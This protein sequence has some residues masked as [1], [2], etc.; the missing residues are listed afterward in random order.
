MS[1]QPCQDNKLRSDRCNHNGVRT[2]DFFGSRDFEFG[3]TN[4]DLLRRVQANLHILKCPQLDSTLSRIR[5]L[6][7]YKSIY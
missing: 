6:K 3:A 4:C 2:S 1:K 7:K 5:E